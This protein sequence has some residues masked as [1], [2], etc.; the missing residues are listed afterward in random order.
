MPTYRVIRRH[1]LTIQDEVVV[2]ADSKYEAMVRA[3]NMEHYPLPAATPRYSRTTAV[4]A[5][6]IKKGADA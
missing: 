4:D 3:E 2:E 1:Y 6:E 5:H